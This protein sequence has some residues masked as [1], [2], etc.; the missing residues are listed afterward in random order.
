MSPTCCGGDVVVRVE[1]VQVVHAF[2]IL[3]APRAAL[4]VV[5]RVARWVVV[6]CFGVANVQILME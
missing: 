3:T 5:V 1:I 4:A 6:V 2:R